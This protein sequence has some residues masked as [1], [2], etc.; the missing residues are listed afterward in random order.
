MKKVVRESV[1]GIEVLED[2]GLLYG[3]ERTQT[4]RLTGKVRVYGRVVVDGVEYEYDVDLV[5]VRL[6]KVRR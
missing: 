6:E 1:D 3:V 5:R 4:G 2:G